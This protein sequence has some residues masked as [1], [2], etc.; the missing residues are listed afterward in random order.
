MKKI[1]KKYKSYFIITEKGLSKI[2]PNYFDSVRSWPHA[3]AI[4][5]SCYV[6]LQKILIE[7]AINNDT[8]YVGNM[9]VTTGLERSLYELNERYPT[10][11]KEI[12]STPLFVNGTRICKC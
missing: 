4:G 5:V 8:S 2:D 9:K 1:K 3:L 10:L 6:E 12:Y 7:D 11:L